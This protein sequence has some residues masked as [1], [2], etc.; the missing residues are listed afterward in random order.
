M[1]VHFKAKYLSSSNGKESTC[2]VGDPGL[3]PGLGGSPGEGHGSSLQYSCVEN[4]RTE[5]PGRLHS[6]VLQNVGHAWA[7]NVILLKE[8]SLCRPRKKPHWTVGNVDEIN[9]FFKVRRM[10]VFIIVNSL[11]DH[12]QLIHW[13]F[14]YTQV[15]G[16]EFS[17][18][19]WNTI[20]EIYTDTLKY[21]KCM[22]WMPCVNIPML[23]WWAVFSFVIFLPHGH[24]HQKG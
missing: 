14:L 11:S 6:M 13:Y 15:E 3:I 22:T 17:V 10:S 9:P 24:S 18:W 7:T 4:P 19:I 5:E 20:E 23:C 21:S 16:K 8:R 1:F 2:N 12:L